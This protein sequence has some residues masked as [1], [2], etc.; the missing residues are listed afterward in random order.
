M[1]EKHVE[2]VIKELRKHINF[3]DEGSWDLIH[4]SLTNLKLSAGRPRKEK[5]PT[6]VWVEE[7]RD[8]AREYIKL[9]GQCDIEAVKENIPIPEQVSNRVAGGLFRHTDFIKIGTRMADVPPEWGV[10]PREVG[11]YR[12]RE[13]TDEPQRKKRVIEV[14]PEPDNEGIVHW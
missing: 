8:F 4:D 6:D 11:V 13:S 14:E 9:H 2:Q 10:P 12:L 5:T 3:K 7:A 1:R